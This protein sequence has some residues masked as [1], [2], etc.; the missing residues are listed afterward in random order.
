MSCLTLPEGV[1]PMRHLL[2]VPV[3]YDRSL[4]LVP[5]D[6]V[7]SSQF[8]Y[9]QLPEGPLLKPQAEGP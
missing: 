8:S 2:F 4:P 3:C 6:S 9:Y 5:L 1:W 7:G